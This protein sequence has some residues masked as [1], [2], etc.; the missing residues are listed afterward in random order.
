MN[1]EDYV[2]LWAT[3]VH[4]KDAISK[5]RQRELKQYH[6]SAEQ[7]GVLSILR[8]AQGSLTPAEISR[9][10]YR[11]PSSVTVIL[12]R[13]MAKGLISK[14][15]D[16]KR[17]NLIKVSLTK[18]GDGLYSQ[19]LEE[20]CVYGLFSVLSEKQCLQLKTC[21]GKLLTEATGDLRKSS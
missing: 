1:Q 5:L 13:M 3:L 18:K 6:I 8:G 12:K 7:T 19:I 16:K 20:M 21:L 9:R 2:D 10:L 11:D 4:T 14:T 17:K 15:R